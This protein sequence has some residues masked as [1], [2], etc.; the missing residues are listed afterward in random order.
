MTFWLPFVG[1]ISEHYLGESA[2]PERERLI[3]QH[4]V[5]RAPGPG[6]VAMV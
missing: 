3:Q 1:G 5:K 4:F 2:T 6:L